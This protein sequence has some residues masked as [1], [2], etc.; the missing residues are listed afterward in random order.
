[1]GSAC[2]YCPIISLNWPKKKEETGVLATNFH[3]N[4]VNSHPYSWLCPLLRWISSYIVLPMHSRGA[5]LML[6]L[7][8]RAMMSTATRHPVIHV[9]LARALTHTDAIGTRC[10]LTHRHHHS[11]TEVVSQTHQERPRRQHSLNVSISCIRRN[12][13]IWNLPCFTW[14]SARLVSAGLKTISLRL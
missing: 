1:M 14:L 6:T 8:G 7:I 5:P 13:S 4:E 12:L 9:Y 2:L 11:G 10:W 3:F